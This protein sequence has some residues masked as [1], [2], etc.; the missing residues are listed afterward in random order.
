M[1]KPPNMRAEMISPDVISLIR[2]F[3]KGRRNSIRGAISQYQTY[4]LTN[5]IVD[6]IRNNRDPE[7]MAVA[8]RLLEGAH[9]L[10]LKKAQGFRQKELW[11]TYSSV[12]RGLELETAYACGFLN[13]WP[14]L[15]EKAAGTIA[16]LS[17]LD[18]CDDED[19]CNAVKVCAEEWGASRYLCYK[20]AFIKSKVGA[21][22][23]E[24]RSLRDA[25]DILGHEES[26]ALQY[27]ALENLK[28]SISIFSV[29]RRH[30]NTL[31]QRV[32]KNFRRSHSLNNLVA[33]P[34]S[35]DDAA[36]FLHRSVETTLLDT[37]HALWVLKNLED[38]FPSFKSALE[39]HLDEKLLLALEKS[40][41]QVASTQAPRLIKEP[42]G[43]ADREKVDY[44]QEN[45]LTIYR[46]SAAFLEH[47]ALCR[48]RNDVDRVIG[49]RLVASLQPNI[50]KW[51]GASFDD[52]EV[53][54]R[55]NNQ[56][57]LNLHEKKDVRLDTFYR[58]YLFLRF[59]QDPV[60]LSYMREGDIKFLFNNTMGLDALLT[61]RELQ[62]MHLNASEKIAPLVSV[63]ALALHRGRSSDPDVD[64]EYRLML[65]SYI[66][67]NFS[68]DIPS[69]IKSLL[70]DSPQ[71]ASY[72]ATSLSEA[73]LQKMYQLVQSPQQAS[74]IRKDILSSIGFSLNRIEYIIEAEAIETRGKVDSLRKYF[75]TSRMFVDSISMQNW[76]EANP[77]AYTQQYKELLP[78]LVTRLAAIASI[79]DDETGETKSIPIVQVSTS[80]DH[81]VQ[82]ISKEAFG[83][84]CTNAE[85][86]IESYLGRRIRHNTLH[87]VMID[88]VESILD[89][90]VFQPVIAGTRFGSALK[91]WQNFYRSYIERMR[92]EFLQFHS[93]NKPNA[94]FSSVLDIS[95]SAT[96]RSVSE[97]S[98]TLKVSGAEMLPDL[99]ISFC[100]RQIAPQ[101][102]IASRKIKVGMAGDVKNN[103]DATLS[104]FRGP[105]EQRVISELNDAVDGVFSKVASWFRVPETGF[106]S[107]TIGALCNIID[108]EFGREESPTV[109]TGCA[110]DTEYYGISV[111]RLYDCL[112]VLIQ[113]AIKHG[114]IFGRIT[115]HAN[116]H[117]IPN[118]NLHEVCVS[119]TSF[120]DDEE[121]DSCVARIQN[122]IDSTETGKDM[123]TEGYS[124]LKKLKYITKLNEGRH[125][126]ELTSVGNEVEL[127]FTLRVEVAERQGVDEKS[128]ID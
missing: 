64:F 43:H 67:E 118:T 70:S 101:L 54:R 35:T 119:V 87:G 1:A 21:M 93:D 16:F 103:L 36:A 41:A 99:I 125:T 29:A 80:V 40:R 75:D 23:S 56:F 78:K 62:T 26:P 92:K 31:R 114:E 46:E 82:Q 5:Q 108:I 60:N 90:Q 69:F 45:S 104:K 116:T 106:V 52:V 112:A 10:K 39:E 22:A 6:L 61:E 53:L 123:V 127:R 32:G 97:L 115:V 2:K 27:S 102:E 95:D 94:L 98:E 120:V 109:V 86:G 24:L 89:Q 57:C 3:S 88:P 13:S 11:C 34:V 100:W 83:E 37:V 128:S 77:S 33:T 47:S 49:V 111:H 9:G 42:T 105:E 126:V 81:L 68:G 121:V 7:D 12:D 117:E 122:A 113:N 38:R 74:S 19:A 48:F 72:L 76:L 65:E 14:E 58:T 51:T 63:L 44:E 15:T 8:A 110:L 18:Q 4:G 79:R 96:R 71:I 55:N 17:E 124:G 30:T 50:L 84:F 59:I 20:I 85:F 28:S 66:S 25:D 73:T 91:Q 107:A